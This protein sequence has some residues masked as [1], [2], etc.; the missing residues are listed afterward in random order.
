VAIV[1][2]PVN[3][4]GIRESVLVHYFDS[5]GVT[6][7]VAKSYDYPDNGCAETV[8]VDLRWI[9]KGERVVQHKRRL[10]DQDRYDID[11]ERC[12]LGAGDSALAHPSR[13]AYSRTLR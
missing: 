5:T 6:V 11:T 2:Q 3:Q 12:V 8:M 7:A 13:A 10:I 9:V 1:E 4:Y